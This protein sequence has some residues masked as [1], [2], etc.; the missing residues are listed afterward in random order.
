[1]LSLP[2][3]HFHTSSE[4]PVRDLFDGRLRIQYATSLLFYDK[5]SIYRRLLYQLKYK[6]K[7]EAGY[8]LG[9]LL[10]SRIQ[11]SNLKI[12]DYII[13]VPLHPSKQRRRGYNQSAILA[14]GVSEILGIPV[15]ENT[16]KRTS[17]T[18]TQTQKGR[19][20]RWQNVEAVFECREVQKLKNKHV[21]LIDDVV[22][23]G[24]TLEAAGSRLL[25][26]E[27]LTLSLATAAYTSS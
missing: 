1:M 3:T 24:A 6:G 26:I 8:F 7:K 23:T 2:E 12:P 25:E 5:G 4:H 14:R 19:F 9:R 22:T 16:L 18:Q 17:H 15:L 13:P 27:G 11:K 21:L 20:E 10:G